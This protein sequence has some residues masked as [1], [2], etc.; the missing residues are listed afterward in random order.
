MPHAVIEYSANLDAFVTSR[1]AVLA[2]HNVMLDSGLFSPEAVKTRAHN[3]NQFLV[4]D[5]NADAS[6][7]HVWIALME[8]RPVE[9]K[10]ALTQAMFSALRALVPEATS[11]S[12]D[13]RD[14]DSKTYRK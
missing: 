13:I 3:V 12:V 9:K 11:V 6:F 8:G 1:Q 7:I 2:A 10:Q 4:G 14:M 5:D